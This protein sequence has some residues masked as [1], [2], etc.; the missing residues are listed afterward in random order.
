MAVTIIWPDN[1]T[2]T[3]TLSGTTFSRYA[4]GP[5][6]DKTLYGGACQGRYGRQSGTAGSETYRWIKDEALTVGTATTVS[7]SYDVV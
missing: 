4:I 3:E 6:K 1:H 5:P 2:S 7:F